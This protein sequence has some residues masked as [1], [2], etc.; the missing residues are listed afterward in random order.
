MGVPLVQVLGAKNIIGIIQALKPGIGEKKLPP[1]LLTPT[2][3]VSGNYGTYHK[4]IGERR[5][6][7]TSNYGAPAQV[8]EPTGV[9]EVPVNFLHSF[10]QMAFGPTNLLNLLQEGDEVRQKLGMQTIARQTGDFAQTY[11]NLRVLA[12]YQMLATGAIT[13]DA[14]GS[15]TTKASEVARTLSFGIP[16][17]NTGQINIPRYDINGKVV[18]SPIISASWATV[19]TSILQQ[20]QDLR[21]VAAQYTGYPLSL[22]FC[23]KNVRKYLMDNTEYKDY[24][25]RYAPAQE[26]AFKGV[27]PA[28]FA[29]FTWVEMTETFYSRDKVN[30]GGSLSPNI[31]ALPIFGPDTVTFT[32]DITSEWYDFIEGSYPVPMGEEEGKSATEILRRYEEVFGHFGWAKRGVDSNPSTIVEYQG[33]TFLPVIKVPQA[34]FIA[35]VANF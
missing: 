13:T 24:M 35:K 1:A 9:A 4:V 15:I 27:I 12:V 10:N 6:A 34:V 7:K 31:P 25:K 23:G 3:Q 2:R 26:A 30:D 21:E 8:Y 29:D 32:P 5:A 33:D 18:A 11:R 17:T 19:G 14:Q 22:A 28:G 20:L 16:S